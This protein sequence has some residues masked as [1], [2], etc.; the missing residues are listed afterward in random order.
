MIHRL[1]NDLVYDAV[2]YTDEVIVSVRLEILVYVVAV[3]VESV[4]S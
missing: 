1:K 3:L 4:R 2:E